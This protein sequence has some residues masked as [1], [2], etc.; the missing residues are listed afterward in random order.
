MLC[1]FFLLIGQFAEMNLSSHHGKF[2]CNCQCFVSLRNALLGRGMKMESHLNNSPF[3]CHFLHQFKADAC[4][5]WLLPCFIVGN[6]FKQQIKGGLNGILPG[7]AGLAHG[8]HCVSTFTLLLV[9]IIWHLS[10]TIF[11]TQ[12][13]A[14][15]AEYPSKEKRGWFRDIH[16]I[17]SEWACV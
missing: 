3:S 2:S 14:Y 16:T 4:S 5:L 15:S 17:K 8:C 11:G 10:I 7:I 9:E 6:F 13:F 12:I 1:I